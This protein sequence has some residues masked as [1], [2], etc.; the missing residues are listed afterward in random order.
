MMELTMKNRNFNG[1]YH[2]EEECGFN[3]K[4]A[5][6]WLYYIIVNYKQ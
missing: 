3:Q 5:Y 6:T 1:F 2:N 4:L